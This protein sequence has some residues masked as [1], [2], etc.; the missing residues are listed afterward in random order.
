MESRPISA[1]R[2]K[3]SST[4][5]QSSRQLPLRAIRKWRTHAPYQNR[6]TSAMPPPEYWHVPPR[7]SRDLDLPPVDHAPTRIQCF[8]TTPPV[9]D[10]ASHPSKYSMPQISFQHCSL[11]RTPKA[12][13]FYARPLACALTNRCNAI[14]HRPLA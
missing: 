2:K 10:E 12:D 14:Y 8:L 13:A 1:G 6:Q 9:D 5:T 7:P 11:V 3:L 4:N